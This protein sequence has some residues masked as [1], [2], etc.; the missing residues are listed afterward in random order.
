[1]ALPA[2]TI[3]GA[4]VS[5]PMAD[6]ASVDGRPPG[7]QAQAALAAISPQGQAGGDGGSQAQRPCRKRDEDAPQREG[8]RLV[9]EGGGGGEV[10]GEHRGQGCCGHYQGGA[11]EHRT[12]ET[13]HIKATQGDA[14]K[15]EIV[16]PAA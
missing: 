9:Q 16:T 14:S 5:V 8:Q 13:G 11:L 1:V 7:P 3:A 6:S 2:S 4:A 12:G 15:A 10:V